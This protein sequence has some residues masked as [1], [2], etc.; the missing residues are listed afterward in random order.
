[1]ELRESGALMP[2]DAE[3]ARSRLVS[4]VTI[5]LPGVDRHDW[6]IDRVAEAA[7][8]VAHSRGVSAVVNW[9][10]YEVQAGEA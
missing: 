1:M 2:G 5:S 10:T 9:T 7:E 4:V 3:A 8:Q 6:L